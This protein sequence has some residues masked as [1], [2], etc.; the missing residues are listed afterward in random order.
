[1][2]RRAA[3]WGADLLLAVLAAEEDGPP[4]TVVLE[5]TLRQRP[6]TTGH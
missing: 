1:M 3:V 5:P 4:R 6:S 2:I